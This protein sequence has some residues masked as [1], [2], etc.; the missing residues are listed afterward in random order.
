MS[1]GVEANFG[2]NLLEAPAVTTLGV[3]EVILG[4]EAETM[5]VKETGDVDLLGLQE[6]EDHGEM[7]TVDRDHP[8]L[9][10]LDLLEE[11]ARDQATTANM[12]KRISGISNGR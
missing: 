2:G 8:Q 10:R 4:E 9:H 6:E 12:T 11:Q 3:E 1:R 7:D 5:E